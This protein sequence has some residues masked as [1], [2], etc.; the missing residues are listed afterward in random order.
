M[1][2]K[3]NDDIFVRFSYHEKCCYNIYKSIQR[4]NFE[5]TLWRHHYE[6]YFS[7]W[8]RTIFS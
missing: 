4:A 3:F 2:R 8:F 5:A 1:Q 7:A 6:K